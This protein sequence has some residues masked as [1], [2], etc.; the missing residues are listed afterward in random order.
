MDGL[1]I[2]AIIIAVAGVLF[3][4]FRFVLRI[5]HR[6][7]KIE[8]RVP[9]NLGDRLA[10][11]EE[12]IPENLG[13]RLTRLETQLEFIPYGE[14]LEAFRKLM[15]K[16]PPTSSNPDGSRRTELM[17]KLE[18][19]E[20]TYPEARELQGLVKR[21]IQRSNVDEAIKCAALVGLGILIGYALSELLK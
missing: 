3:T 17:Q 12:R 9:E 18:T 20:L 4:Y 5:E 13:D 1:S 16:I 8:G 19:R 6:L 10:R 14:L 7:T 11:L 21:D 2:A 15:E